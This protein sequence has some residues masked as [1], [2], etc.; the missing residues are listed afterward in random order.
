MSESDDLSVGR[1][2]ATTRN[3]LVSVKPIFLEQQSD[4]QEGR[5]VW[6]YHVHI[7]NQGAMPVQLLSRHWRITDAKGQLSEVRGDGVVGEQPRLEPGQSFEY[8][9]G[10]PLGTPS[11]IM[12]G[13]YQMIAET[14]EQFEVEIPAFS[15]DSP[16]AAAPIH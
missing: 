6:A 10:T 4:P 3:I 14:G 9:S 1:Y 16:D 5:W 8:T 11:G 7:E 13:T 12:Y 2:A 15:L